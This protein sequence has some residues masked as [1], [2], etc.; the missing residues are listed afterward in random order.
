[1]DNSVEFFD[2]EISTSIW[3]DG[4]N[5]FVLGVTIREIDIV[6]L[7][8]ELIGDFDGFVDIVVNGIHIISSELDLHTIGFP[9][10]LEDG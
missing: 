8:M 3:F 6:P 7:L 5:G 2:D 1:M 4:S 9:W 10:P